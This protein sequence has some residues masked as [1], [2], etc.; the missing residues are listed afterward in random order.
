LENKPETLIK[1]RLAISCG[2][3]EVGKQ[4]RN[5]DKAKT[6]NFLYMMLANV[7]LKLKLWFF[8]PPILK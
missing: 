2:N 5:F 7:F 3:S 8:I 1:P 6:S 4:T